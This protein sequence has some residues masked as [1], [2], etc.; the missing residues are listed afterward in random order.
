MSFLSL[1]QQTQKMTI[2][3]E[4]L[5]TLG[6]ALDGKATPDPAVAAATGDVLQALGMAD[7]IGALTAG[8]KDQIR[9]SIRTFFR[10]AGVWL[11][12]AGRSTVWAYDDPFILQNIGK[13]STVILRLFADHVAATPALAERLE[14]PARFLDVGSGVGWL[15]IETARRFP[16]LSVEG[17]DVF[18]QALAL[19]AE[20]LAGSGVAGRVAFR[21]Q[22]VLTLDAPEAYAMAFLAAPFIPE[23]VV[24]AAL[25]RLFAA[26]EPGGTLFVGRFGGAVEP[27][28]QS[29]TT[30]RIV[31]SG[32]HP[33][34][35]DG[36]ETALAG[37]GF[38]VKTELGPVGPA[39][40][41]IARKPG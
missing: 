22:D 31:R 33:W 30:L 39:I 1:M 14:R 35:R 17:I 10:Q 25:P 15:S 34:T 20:N 26:L 18:P 11:D 37:A 8:E 12:H 36:I 19:A 6:A 29:V 27:L 13:A 41:N 2:Q 23:G 7:E 21:R 24:L 28:A 4:A 3:M 40:V 16:M 9:S 38:E 5:A 32:G